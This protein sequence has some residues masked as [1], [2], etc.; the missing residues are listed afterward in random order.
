MSDL[1]TY[2][3]TKVIKATPMTRGEYNDYRGWKLPDDE[4]GSDKGYLVEYL[5]GD[6]SNHPNHKGYISWSPEKTFEESYQTTDRMN[7]G[8]ALEMLKQ[9]KA[10]S[11]RGWNGKGM[12]LYLV[13]ANAYPVQTQIAAKYFGVGSMVPYGAYIAMKTAEGNVVPWLCSQTDALSDDWGV[14]EP[15]DH[16]EAPTKKFK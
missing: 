3:G 8:H 16:I 9:G 1:Q 5:N 12:F 6:T 11:R 10:V 13:P 2:I 7:F 4:D 14:V 15:Q